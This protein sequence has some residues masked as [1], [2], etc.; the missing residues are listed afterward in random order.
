VNRLGNGGNWRAE[1]ADVREDRV[2]MYGSAGKEVGEYSYRI[3]ATSSGSFIVPP[4][5]VESLYER[6]VQ[7]RAAAS[8]VTVERATK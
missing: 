4:A 6:E 8:R 2:V 3:K 5:Y 7:G 1:Y